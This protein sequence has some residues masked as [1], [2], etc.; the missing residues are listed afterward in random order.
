MLAE[1]VQMGSSTPLADILVAALTWIDNSC[2]ENW[3]CAIQC[4]IVKYLMGREPIVKISTWNVH[5]TT[6]TDVIILPCC[7]SVHVGPGRSR[8]KDKKRKKKEEK[9]EEERSQLCV[10]PFCVCVI[11]Y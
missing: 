1:F 3:A 4:D 8:V 10:E 6:N 7:T 2:R 5:R 9:P 11:K